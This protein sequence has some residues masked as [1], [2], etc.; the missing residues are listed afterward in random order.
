MQIALVSVGCNDKFYKTRT[1]FDTGSTRTYVTEELA[2]ILKAKPA[3]LQTFSVYL[4]GNTKVKQET[5][6]DW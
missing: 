2:K 4:F 6:R 3:E 5:S 1:I